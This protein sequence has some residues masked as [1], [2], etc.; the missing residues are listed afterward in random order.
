MTGV[1]RKGNVEAGA[2][3]A[4]AGLVFVAAVLNTVAHGGPLGAGDPYLWASLAVA[5][6]VALVLVA[7]VRVRPAAALLGA[8]GI[9][10]FNAALVYEVARAGGPEP[11]PLAV[12]AVV[13]AGA[14]AVLA[15]RGRPEELPEGVAITWLGAAAIFELSIPLV[16]A[17]AG[18]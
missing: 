1:A 9:V 10:V 13:A 4:V 11:L 3:F 14:A 7:L 8:G 17:V 12:V 2:G 5:A 16:R 6:P 15:G 18:A